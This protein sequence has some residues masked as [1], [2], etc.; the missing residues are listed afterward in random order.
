MRSGETRVRAN[1]SQERVPQRRGRIDNESE[2]KTGIKFAAPYVSYHRPGRERGRMGSGERGDRAN[3]RPERAPPR[4]G[5][6]ALGV[7]YFVSILDI[8]AI[9]GARV[10]H[11]IAIFDPCNDGN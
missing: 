2:G 6:C 5:L 11:V 1:A 3:G 9:G 7:L 4:R 10:T 8:V